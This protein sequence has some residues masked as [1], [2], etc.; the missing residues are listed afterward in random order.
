[1]L[2]NTCAKFGALDL[3]V[4][5]LLYLVTNGKV[6]QFPE[7]FGMRF[8][9]YSIDILTPGT[10]MGLVYL[11]VQS[12]HYYQKWQKLVEK[13]GCKVKPLCSR[14]CKC[15]EAGFPCTTLCKCSRVFKKLK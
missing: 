13:C 2:R 15:H 7:G 6:E 12:G 11:W 1:M 4:T 14:K 10:C 3:C 5:I 8:H 9:G